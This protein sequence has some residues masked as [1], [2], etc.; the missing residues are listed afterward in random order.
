L[1]FKDALVSNGDS[2]VIVVGYQSQRF[3]VRAAR[4]AATNSYCPEF[5]LNA[6]GRER[7]PA[8]SALPPLSLLLSVLSLAD[9]YR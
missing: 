4:G 3:S 8:E 7:S 5:L 9:Y 6:G 2:D 1:R